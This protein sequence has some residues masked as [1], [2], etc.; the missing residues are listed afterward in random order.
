MTLLVVGKVDD[1]SALAA[2]TGEA[3]CRRTRRTRWL[4]ERRPPR[5]TTTPWHLA[6]TPTSAVP[7]P[8]QPVRASLG[9]RAP[10]RHPTHGGL[11]R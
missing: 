10:T 11:V 9:A 5:R 4:D 3:C 6:P 8:D 2:W 7:E 1:P